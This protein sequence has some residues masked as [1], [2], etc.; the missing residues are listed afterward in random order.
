MRNQLHR[1]KR[2][3]KK[4][5]FVTGAVRTARAGA[6]DLKQFYWRTIRGGRIQNYLRSHPVRKL[7]LGSSFTPLDG[8]L[9]TD[10]IPE[11]PGVVYLDATRQFPFRDDTFDYVA[12]EHMIEHIDYD[13]GTAM[14]QES[15]RVLKPGG[16]IRIATPDLRV[17]LR[18]N[19]LEKTPDQTEYIE[20]IASKLFPRIT[21]C[22]S[23]FVINNAFR[24]WGHQFLY[25]AE[26]LKAALE[27]CGFAN[28]RDHKPGQ[29]DDSHLRGIESHGTHM[30]SET[31]N[32]FETLVVEARVPDRKTRTIEPSL[33]SF[34]TPSGQP[35]A[36][37]L[38][39][40]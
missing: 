16:A 10:L 34:N 22:K 4:S 27:Y 24:C 21:H 23:A 5:G 15:F 36:G 37:T 7:Q 38:A 9:N 28:F 8:W 1:F 14:L 6:L 35:T 11:L 2:S 12:C 25:D 26:T 30:G 32:Q 39:Q 13:S 19:E 3:I 17:L 40:K 18:L 33:E 29:S 31:I 20:W